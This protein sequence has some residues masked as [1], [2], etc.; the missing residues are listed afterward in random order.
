MHENTPE[1]TFEPELLGSL[2][3]QTKVRSATFFNIFCTAVLFPVSLVA[4][5]FFGPGPAWFGKAVTATVTSKK[6]TYSYGRSGGWDYRVY[7][8]YSY[9]GTRHSGTDNTMSFG[10]YAGWKIGGPVTMVVYP[11]VPGDPYLVDSTAPRILTICWVVEMVLEAILLVNIP[12]TFGKQLRLLRY[13]LPVVARVIDIGVS[14]TR[15]MGQLRYAFEIDGSTY[16]GSV[17]T[18]FYDVRTRKIESTVTVL[19]MPDNP[20]MNMAYWLGNDIH[21]VGRS[22]AVR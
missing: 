14:Q 19:S 2:P 12:L 9:G 17:F 3:R 8:S 10:E 21:V 15:T 11:L 20:R 13:G 4:I 7:V 5:W 22:T 1:H 16:E 6:A 18:T